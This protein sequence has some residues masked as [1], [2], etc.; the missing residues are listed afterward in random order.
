[1]TRKPPAQTALRDNAQG[2]YRIS[3][4]RFR[5]G[6]DPFLTTLDSQRSYY[7]AEKSLL[8]VRLTRE[9]NAVE[10]YRALGGGLR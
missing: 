2:A 9:A 6:I 7:N 8:A 4:A 3:E 1:M 10:L 5:T